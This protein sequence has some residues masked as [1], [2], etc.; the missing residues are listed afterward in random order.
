VTDEQVAAIF[1]EVETLR[2]EYATT[3]HA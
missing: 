3:E 2:E 1:E